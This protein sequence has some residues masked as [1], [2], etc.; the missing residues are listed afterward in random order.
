MVNNNSAFLYLH[1]GLQLGI[2][3]IEIYPC[4]LPISVFPFIH[5]R[6]FLGSWAA[7]IASC[8]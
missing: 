7:S 2:T 3:E 4:S 1:V 8:C 6:S 5:L